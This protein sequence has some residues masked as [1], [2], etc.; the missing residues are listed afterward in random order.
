M[1]ENVV[2][3]RKPRSLS[4]KTYR[5]MPADSLGSMKLHSKPHCPW[6]NKPL[7]FLYGDFPS[8]VICVKC[9][10]CGNLA[11]VYF[12]EFVIKKVIPD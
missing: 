1:T 10:T 6:C 8:G 5:M 9:R 3:K 2:N 12:P 4:S 7:I 11:A